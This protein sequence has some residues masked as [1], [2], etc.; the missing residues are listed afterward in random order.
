MCELRFSGR[1]SGR[2][3]SPGTYRA[4]AVATDAAGNTSGVSRATFTVRRR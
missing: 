1:R 4:S 3:L 2:N